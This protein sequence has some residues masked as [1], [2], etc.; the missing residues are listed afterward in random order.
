ML[1]KRAQILFDEKLWN[2]LTNRARRQKTSVGKL[3][4]KAVEKAYTEVEDKELKMRQK[5][6]DEIFKIRKV[7]KTPI[8]Y[9]ALIDYGRK[10]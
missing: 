1:T 9:K 3:V 8:D 2:Q 6:I 10:Y 5:A 4:R 7:S